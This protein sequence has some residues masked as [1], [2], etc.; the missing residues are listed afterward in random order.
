MAKCRA[1][2][3]CLLSLRENER[4][5]T[6]HCHDLSS[7]VTLRKDKRAQKDHRI[8]LLPSEPVRILAKCALDRGRLK[9]AQGLLNAS[10]RPRSVKVVSVV[11]LLPAWHTEAPGS[12]QA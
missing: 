3:R 5:E 12:S 8:R 7:T 4:Q 1:G 9:Q 10:S 2:A 6:E 11:C